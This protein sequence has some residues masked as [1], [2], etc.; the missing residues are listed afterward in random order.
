MKPYKDWL[1]EQIINGN[2][3]KDSFEEEL[4]IREKEKKEL[5]LSYKNKLCPNCN[6]LRMY[7]RATFNNWRCNK[8][9]SIIS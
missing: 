4:T 7:Y 2:I 9:N 6:R 3:L 1:I 5:E 8:C